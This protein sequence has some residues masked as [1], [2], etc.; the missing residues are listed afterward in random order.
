MGRPDLGRIKFNTYKVVD[1]QVLTNR[2]FAAVTATA[3]HEFIHI[4]GFDASL[5]ATFLNPSTGNVYSAVTQNVTT[6]IHASRTAITGDTH[7]VITPHVVAW[8]R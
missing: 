3:M 4:L 6:S 5:Y 2:L 1:G 8:V 7:A